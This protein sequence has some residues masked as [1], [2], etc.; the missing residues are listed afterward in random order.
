MASTVEAVVTYQLFVYI[1]W[2][3]ETGQLLCW[4]TTAI[5]NTALRE[6]WR[7]LRHTCMGE[8]LITM[9]RLSHISAV[10]FGRVEMPKSIWVCFLLV[11]PSPVRCHRLCSSTDDLQSSKRSEQVLFV[12]EQPAKALVCSTWWWAIGTWLKIELKK[13]R[14]TLLYSL[15]VLGLTWAQLDHWSKRASNGGKQ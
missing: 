12:H 4:R 8:I 2:L 10:D 5:F 15:C 3:S 9:D 11:P 13:A 7:K 6:T 1:C 14:E